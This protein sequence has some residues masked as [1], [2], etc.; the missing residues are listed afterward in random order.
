V[1]AYALI[2]LS[3]KCDEEW[4]VH[5]EHC[6]LIVRDQMTWFGA[7]AHCRR[8][9]GE[10]FTSGTHENEIASPMDGQFIWS[11]SATNKILNTEIKWT[12]SNGNKL[13]RKSQKIRMDNSYCVD[14][15]GYVRNRTVH[16][17]STCNKKRTFICGNEFESTTGGLTST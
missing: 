14:G 17:T 6:S 4:S 9:Q 10:L 2:F 16:L 7:Y 13:D 11:G 8:L 15:C 12:W 5:G 1:I 3:G